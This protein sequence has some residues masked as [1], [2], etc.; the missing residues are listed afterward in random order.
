MFLNA[1]NIG[2]VPTYSNIIISRYVQH[3]T[4]SSWRKST[5]VLPMGDGAHH[6]VRRSL[7]SFNHRHFSTTPRVV[8][9]AC[10]FRFFEKTFD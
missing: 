3:Y 4:N 5:D 6:V 8:R 10:S 9:S 2:T 1:Y 7:K